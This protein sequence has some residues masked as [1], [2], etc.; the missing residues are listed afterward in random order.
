MLLLHSVAIGDYKHAA[1]AVTIMPVMNA[2]TGP[3]DLVASG[4]VFGK[5]VDAYL[6]CRGVVLGWVFFLRFNT[7]PLSGEP[8]RR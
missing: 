5:C 7:E 8:V 6:Q 4:C 1:P 3:L 2:L